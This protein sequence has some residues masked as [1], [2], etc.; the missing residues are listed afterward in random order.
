M[1]GCN[2]YVVFKIFFFLVIVEVNFLVNKIIF[3]EVLIVFFYNDWIR[4]LFD[5]VDRLRNLNV[6]K[7]GI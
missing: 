2:K 5:I 3:I 6:M 1:V 7:E 4:L